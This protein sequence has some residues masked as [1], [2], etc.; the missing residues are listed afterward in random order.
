MQMWD[1]VTGA[2]LYEVAALPLAEKLPIAFNACRPGRRS[3][4][5]RDDLP[6]ELSWV[7]AQAGH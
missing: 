6:A 7:E 3:I 2:V 5:W 4:S 1:A